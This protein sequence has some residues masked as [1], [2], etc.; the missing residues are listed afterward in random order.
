MDTSRG[1]FGIAVRSAFLRKGTQ[2]RYSLFFLA[3]LC[4]ILIFLESIDSKPLN[5]TRSVVKDL[6][7]RGAV[8]ASYPLKTFSSSYG[9]VADHLN[10]Y[11]DYQNLKDENSQLKSRIS[12]TDFLKLENTQLRKL[13][14][15]QVKSESNL[16]SARVI[17][18]KQSPYLNSFVIN[19]GSN[20][21]IKNG[22]AVL[23]GENFIGRIVDV[24]FFSSRVLLITDL[25]S[26]IAVLTE[27]S[28]DHA[29]LTGHGKNK[30]SLDYMSKDNQVKDG[31]KVYTSGKEGIF[32]PGIIIGEVRK[33]K[34]EFRVEL[35][36]D[37]NKITF[38]NIS[39]GDFNKNK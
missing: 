32:S 11:N 15:E 19:I 25:N 13:I 37:L 7:Y 28:G 35:Y 10:L 16:V 6:I 23:D 17:L 2:Q 8:I 9:V 14:D 24:N 31:D 21:E 27:P 4:L 20:K 30:P 12:K 18:D 3:V 1:D 22:M 38:I 34:E 39:Q 36:S 29:I 26:K 33:D 5:K